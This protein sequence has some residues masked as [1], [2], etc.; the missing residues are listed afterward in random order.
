MKLQQLNIQDVGFVY[1]DSEKTP[2]HINGLALFDQATASHPRMQQE[3]IVAYI[4]TRL[5]QAP[6][7]TK[8][9]HHAPME[10]ER[11]YW[12]EDQDFNLADH[13]FQITLDKPGNKQQLNQLIS[14]IMSKPLDMDKPLWQI[15]FI[16]GL[17]LE[18][19]APN[20]FAMLTKIHHCCIDGASGN[21]LFSTLFDREANPEHQPVNKE[22]NEDDDNEVLAM[23]GRFEMLASAYGRNSISAWAQ[24]V[25]VSKRLPGI[26]NAAVQ[27]FRG[28]I[29]SGAKLA[30]PLTRFNRTP[31]VERSF[32]FTTFS[33]SD[34]KAIK[35]TN[36]GTTVNDVM[37]CIIAGALRKF[38][39]SKGEL[40]E[41]SMG[42]MMPKNLREGEEHEAKSGNRVG[43]LFTSIHTDIEDA[44]TRLKAISKS[45]QAAKAFSNELDTGTIFPNL[46]GGFLYPKA[47]KAF[48]KFAQKHNLMERLGPVVLNTVITNVPGPTFDLFHAG[49]LQ[50]NFIAI[51]PLTDGIALAH[52]IYSVQDSLA[53]GVVSC[54]SMID[55]C[56]FYM[57]CCEESFAEL[58]ALVTAA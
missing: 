38:L 5:H 17:E 7:L 40:P 58:M 20:S 32:G 12:I 18:G 29:D 55:D 51:P 6:I 57:Q 37:V 35:K 26:T 25:E 33:L 9:L 34:I 11:P 13:I 54:P 39:E 56:S 53:L 1:Q 41:I 2:M 31:D 45:T 46:M 16:E 44:E 10:L 47:G 50:K 15:Y 28:K 36:D 24:T 27:L 14:E 23:P 21:N 48:T 43:G 49:A 42:A 3:E 52:A 19:M 22:D 4:A 30:V 8:K